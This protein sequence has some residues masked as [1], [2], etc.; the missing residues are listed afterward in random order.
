[1]NSNEKNKTSQVV[2]MRW[3]EPLKRYVEDEKNGT[4]M[5]WS[6]ILQKW[7]EVKK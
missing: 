2:K 7:V 3:S 4:P 5:R 6:K 1:M